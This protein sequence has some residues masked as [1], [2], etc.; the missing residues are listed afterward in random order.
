MPGFSG[1]TAVAVI[2]RELGKKIEEIYETFD[3]R[4]IA[5]A[6]LGVCVCERERERERECARACV[7]VFVCE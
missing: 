3:R 7:W 2:E 1:D 6:S 4:P 5:A